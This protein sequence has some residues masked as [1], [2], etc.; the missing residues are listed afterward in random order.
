MVFQTEETPP[1]SS[2]SP[3]HVKTYN[4]LK[5]MWGKLK[6][7]LVKTNLF[8]YPLL[9]SVDTGNFYDKKVGPNIAKELVGKRVEP[10]ALALLEIKLSFLSFM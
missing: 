7:S 6:S 1:D 5:K 8:L 2:P 9:S 3:A 10:L 4:I